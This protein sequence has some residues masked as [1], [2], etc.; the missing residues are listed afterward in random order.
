MWSRWSQRRFASAC[1]SSDAGITGVDLY[2]ASF[3]P[4]LKSSPN[5][6]RWSVALRAPR[7]VGEETQEA[8]RPVP[9]EIDP[10]ASTPEDALTAAR[11]EVKSWRLEQLTHRKARTDMDPVTAWFGTGLGRVC[12]TSLSPTTKLCAWRVGGRRHWRR[13]LWV[14]WAIK[15]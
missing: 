12:G 1:R 6:G 15:K 14:V 7:R 4:A 2:L 3:G 10:Y 8:G 11:R 5:S 13:I 9:E